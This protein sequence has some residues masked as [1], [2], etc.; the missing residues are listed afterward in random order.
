MGVSP[1][2][3]NRPQRRIFG[4]LASS[5]GESLADMP[6]VG[7]KSIDDLIDLRLVE[8]APQTWAGKPCYRL[9][10]AGKEM[11]EELFRLKLIPR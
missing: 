2:D 1:K 4:Y 7:Q 8:I 11:H 3:L 9:T 6:L 5:E 10:T